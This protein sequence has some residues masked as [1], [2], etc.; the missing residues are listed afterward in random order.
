MKGIVLSVVITL[1]LYG[2]TFAQEKQSL[3]LPIIAVIVGAAGDGITTT[4][5]LTYPGIQETNPVVD[6]LLNGRPWLVLPYKTVGTVGIV[7]GAK[8]LRD[9]GHPLLAKIVLWSYAALSGY[10]AIHNYRVIQKIRE[11][12]VAEIATGLLLNQRKC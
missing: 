12:P 8:E 9:R 10:L 2:D 11:R 5:A 7:Y 4:V 3:K 6:G 1:F